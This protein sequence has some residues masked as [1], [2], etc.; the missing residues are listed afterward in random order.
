MARNRQH[1][2]RGSRSKLRR[3]I[4]SGKRTSKQGKRRTGRVVKKQQELVQKGSRSTLLRTRSKPMTT[5]LPTKM[6][7]PAVI[8]THRAWHETTKTTRQHAQGPLSSLFSSSVLNGLYYSKRIIFVRWAD[9]SDLV[10]V[11]FRR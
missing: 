9:L 3:T 5:P 7:K 8:S 6:P 11:H 2:K 4:P 1:P 10:F